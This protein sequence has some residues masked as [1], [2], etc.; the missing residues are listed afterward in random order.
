VCLAAAH[1]A[2]DPQFEVASVKPSPQANGLPHPPAFTGG[3]GTATPNRFTVRDAHLKNL[4]L[5]AYAI[6]DYQLSAPSWVANPNYLSMDGCFDIDATIPPGTTEAQFLVML[7]NLLAERFGLKVHREQKEL[8]VY[9]LSLGKNGH[10]LKE[11]LT[12]E[13]SDPPSWA[14]L[15]KDADG[16]RVMPPGYTGFDMQPGVHNW[17][18]KFTRM[19]VANLVKYLSTFLGTPVQD[20]TGLQG[21]YDFRLDYN[22]RQVPPGSPDEPDLPDLR[23]A[24]ESELGLKLVPG[25]C[26]IEMLVIDHID[27]APS[28]N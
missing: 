23:T 11:N 15:P 4:I 22:W 5:K 12:P 16:F 14:S 8:A 19:R 6:E 18:V 21:N 24:V 26:M 9:F 2:T 3:P 7:Q 27:R 1:A 28:P 10:K 17:R 20:R 25:K 13:L